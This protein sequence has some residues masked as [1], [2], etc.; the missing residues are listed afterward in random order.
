M[1]AVEYSKHLG[2]SGSLLSLY[3]KN[4]GLPKK[5]SSVVIYNTYLA[6]FQRQEEARRKIQDMYYELKDAKLLTKFGLF[7]EANNVMTH[8]SFNV[9]VGRSFRNIE[10][11]I[12]L[13]HVEHYETIIK[14]YEEW[15]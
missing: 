5:T 15:R 8:K 12:G 2:K 10:R 1:T 6:E 7:L 11:L 13:E 14:L 4:R 9:M 3:R